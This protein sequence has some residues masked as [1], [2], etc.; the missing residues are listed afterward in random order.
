[1][2]WYFQK[3]QKASAIRQI[4]FGD[5]RE[6]RDDIEAEKVFFFSIAIQH[7]ENVIS[8]RRS[9]IVTKTVRAVR[10]LNYPKK[11]LS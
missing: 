4:R 2:L 3:A 1:M 6:G 7:V 8:P 9:K 5:L 10:D 11:H